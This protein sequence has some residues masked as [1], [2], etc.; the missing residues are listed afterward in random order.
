VITMMAYGG[1]LLRTVDAG[2]E[3][4]RRSQWPPYVR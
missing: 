1:G 2:P 4:R 3:R